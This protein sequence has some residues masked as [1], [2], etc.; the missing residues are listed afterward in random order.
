MALKHL[1]VAD[2]VFAELLRWL[3]EEKRLSGTLSHLGEVEMRFTA[4]SVGSTNSKNR[5]IVFYPVD[6]LRHEIVH[7]GRRIRASRNPRAG[8]FCVWGVWSVPASGSS[9]PEGFRVRGDC[10]PCAYSSTNSSKVRVFYIFCK[11]CQSRSRTAQLGNRKQPARSPRCRGARRALRPQFGRFLC[12]F[13]YQVPRARNACERRTPSSRRA[14]QA[15]AP[16]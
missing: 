5:T 8:P 12:C 3:L 14:T 13:H 4:I 7:S 9:G 10:V 15:G 1:A 2:F 16:R 6:Y 11:F